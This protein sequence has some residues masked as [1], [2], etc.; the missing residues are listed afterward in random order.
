MGVGGKPE[1]GKQAAEE[2][3]GELRRLF[4]DETE[5]C[6]RDSFNGADKIN[7]V[8]KPS[9]RNESDSETGKA[10]IY[11]IEKSKMCIRDRKMAA[12]Y[13]IILIYFFN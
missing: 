7:S 11:T 2:S 5:M 3:I 10:E 4:D 12:G 1:K 13:A 9:C 6:I 8:A